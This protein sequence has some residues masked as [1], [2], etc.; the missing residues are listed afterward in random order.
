MYLQILMVAVFA[1]AMVLAAPAD[2]TVFGAEYEA[3]DAY[4]PQEPQQF[5]KLK[6]LKKLL[7]LG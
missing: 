3:A 2:E 6:K 7:F 5:F 1:M 4:N